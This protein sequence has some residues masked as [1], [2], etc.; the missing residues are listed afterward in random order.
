MS[1]SFQ[2]FPYAGGLLYVAPQH[3]GPSNPLWETPTGY[4]ATMVGFPYDDMVSWR[5]C[6][7]D[8]V[9]VAQFDKVADGFDRA[10]K[11]C[12]ESAPKDAVSPAFLREMDVAQACA[13]HFRSV[14]NQG[15]FV[16]ERNALA[17]AKTADEAKPHL[18]TLEKMLKSEAELAKRLYVI[19]NRDSRIGFE[20]SNQYYY[21]PT[22][23]AE[24]VVNCRDLLDRWLP[25]ERK[26]TSP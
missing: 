4:T 19:Q 20:A 6:F 2:E 13:I 10:V 9:F 3:V 23:L 5:A 8:D 7:P 16:M 18:E 24:K 17:A 26:K 22:D 14:A 21:V 1:V 12:T 15:R 25:A 11:E